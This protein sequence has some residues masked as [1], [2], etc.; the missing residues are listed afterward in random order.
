MTYEQKLNREAV[1]RRAYS[2][3]KSEKEKE[4]R[5]HYSQL[6]EKWEGRL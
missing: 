4:R 1:I 3:V 2:K 6:R 5:K